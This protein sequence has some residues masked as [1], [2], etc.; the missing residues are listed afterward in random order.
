MLAV[1]LATSISV[2]RVKHIDA[3]AQ[4]GANHDGTSMSV[5][6][7]SGKRTISVPCSIWVMR[8]PMWMQAL[9]G[10]LL[11]LIVIFV[12]T[13]WSDLKDSA[14]RPRIAK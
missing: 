2:W 6:V 9:C 14:E 5:M 8:Q 7:Q 1:L 11:V 10:L 4:V 12:F 13:L 3:C